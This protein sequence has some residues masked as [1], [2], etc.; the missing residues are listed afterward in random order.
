[1]V[2]YE[3]PN[4]VRVYFTCRQQDNTTPFVD[5]IVIGT[6]GTARILTNHIKG[7]NKWKYKGPKPSMYR[8]EHE[9]LFKSIRDGSPI[10]NGEYMTNSTLIAI[11]GRLCTYSGQD[12]RWENVISNTERLGPTE[13][14]WSD[15]PI[16][17]EAIPGSAPVA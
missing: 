8:V 17:A 12:L 13:Y 6:K 14:A 10:N 11:M 3:Y 16:E 9:E 2:F 5:E 4:G 15:L 7:E 1:V